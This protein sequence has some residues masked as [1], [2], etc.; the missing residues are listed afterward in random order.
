MHPVRVAPTYI[1]VNCGQSIV[2]CGL[3][4]DKFM[5]T[6]LNCTSTCSMRRERCQSENPVFLRIVIKT[7]AYLT[8]SIWIWKTMSSLSKQ[9]GL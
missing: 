3:T 6:A 8:I 4:K 5:V 9:G 1:C 2:K 7:Y